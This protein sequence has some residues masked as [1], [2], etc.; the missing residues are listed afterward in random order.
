CTGKFRGMRHGRAAM[1]GVAQLVRAPGCGP[2]CRGFESLRS[3]HVL[4]Q[5]SLRRHIFTSS[6][7]RLS[8][9]PSATDRESLVLAHRS[10]TAATRRQHSGTGGSALVYV[11]HSF[12][13]IT[14]E[15]RWTEP[16]FTAPV[17]L[18]LLLGQHGGPCWPS[19]PSAWLCWPTTP[20]C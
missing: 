19:S 6:V 12:L 17:S 13:Q 14:G 1:V 2:G 4:R 3:P 11:T 5:A 8:R 7:S 9:L 16:E 20:P 10:A 18:V 15:G